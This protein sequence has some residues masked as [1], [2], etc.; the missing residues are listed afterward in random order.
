MYTPD[1]R[2]VHTNERSHE[3]RLK[4]KISTELKIVE[5]QK[6]KKFA[7]N[8]LVKPLDSTIKVFKLFESAIHTISHFICLN[9]VIDQ[10]K[11]FDAA[12][13]KHVRLTMK[14]LLNYKFRIRSL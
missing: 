14:R 8:K 4:A 12:V 5:D 6:L 3:K 7:T 10:D 11:M 9:K 1:V 2:Y 13:F